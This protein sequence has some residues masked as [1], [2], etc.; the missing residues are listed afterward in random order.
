VV[1]V[2]R[3]RNEALV[4][5]GAI[6][7]SREKTLIGGTE[8]YGLVV[9]LGKDGWTGPLPGAYVRAL[10]QEHGVLALGDDPA[11]SFSPGDLAGILPVHS[12]LA[13]SA[14]RHYITLSGE[15]IRCFDPQTY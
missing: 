6:H 4:H 5:A 9:R 7:L 12:C 11:A 14:M 3:T 15:Q 8:V 2:N 10:S 13:V 1:E